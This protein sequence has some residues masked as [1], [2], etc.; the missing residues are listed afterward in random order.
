MKKLF[1]IFV[2]L[3][4]FDTESHAAQIG[5][6]GATLG[7]DQTKL[8]LE[9]D[10]LIDRDLDGAARDVDG[11]NL[12]LKGELGLTKKMD[13]LLRFG[14]GRFEVGSQDSDTGPAYGIGTKMTWASLPNLRIKI[15]SVA[16]MLQLRTD[17]NGTRTSLTEY[18]LALGAYMD[19]AL[20]SPSSMGGLMLRTYGGIA[21]SG[22]D[23]EA[24]GGSTFKEDSSFGLF[25]GMLMDLNRKMQLGVELRIPEQTALSFYTTY[26]F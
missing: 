3:L 7:T 17:T 25:V 11:M 12:L 18:D 10:F 2:V 13:L 6:P 14:F 22:V 16:Q 8:G 21:W 4:I 24:S 26:S 19:E 9:L 23:I 5:I 1:V 15:G 20:S